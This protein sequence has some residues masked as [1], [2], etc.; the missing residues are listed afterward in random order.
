[1]VGVQGLEFFAAKSDLRSRERKARYRVEARDL[2]EM[3]GAN[4]LA[5]VLSRRLIRAAL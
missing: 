2:R 1:M 3:D 4:G 5:W